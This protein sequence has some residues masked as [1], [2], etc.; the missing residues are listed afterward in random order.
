MK[1]NPVPLLELTVVL[2]TKTD[3]GLAE[4]F[5]WELLLPEDLS[6]IDGYQ[7][8]G[9]ECLSKLEDIWMCVQSVSQEI[10]ARTGM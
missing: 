9:V 3:P 7:G 4:C 5:H 10:A 2:F 6:G 1:L 8:I